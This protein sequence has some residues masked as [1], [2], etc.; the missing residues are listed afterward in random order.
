MKN[1]NSDD[2]LYI[3]VR[4]F[5]DSLPVGFQSTDS[6]ADINYLKWL[7]TPEEAE[8]VIKMNGVPM[9]VSMIAKRCGKSKKET[10][11]LLVAMTKN[12]TVFRHVA[13]SRV[14][15]LAMN[16]MPGIIEHVVN[17]L[18]R[19]SAE[20]TKKYYEDSNFLPFFTD[21]KQ[22]RVVPVNS[23]V[24]TTSAVATY[25][26]YRDI[27]KQQKLIAVSACAC[28]TK[29]KML[30]KACGQ[31][32]DNELTFGTMAHFRIQNDFGREIDVETALEIIDEA[33]KASLVLVP[34]NTQEPSALCLCCSC[35]CDFLNGLKLLEKPA[36]HVQSGF[37]ARIDPD[38]CTNCET[39]L[40]SCQM[41]AI[42][43]E[44]EM[45]I[46]LAKCI[47]CG[48]CLSTCPGDAVS[49][50]AK[51]GVKEPSPTFQGMIARIAKERELPLG[52]MEEVM[53]NTTMEAGMK[54]WEWLHKLRLAGLVIK[55][56]EKKGLA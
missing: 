31:T 42:N 43:D 17:R 7:F 26:R 56:M 24:D 13:K 35:C 36:E 2:G 6:D 48:L 22:M 39:C 8:V 28:R 29:K 19:E 12:G 11:K 47:G 49:M 4:E 55:M 34:A 27:V 32:I 18:D 9:S 37:L 5:L 23:A 14:L 30:G 20:L 45:Q 51:T 50:V 38:L 41:E 44:E 16:Y 25:D 33:E 15:Y 1:L 10:E 54:K 3:K 46:N 21:Q 53:N 40:E 52:E